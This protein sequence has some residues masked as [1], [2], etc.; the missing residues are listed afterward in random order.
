M[1]PRHVNGDSTET[2]GATLGCNRLTCR[3]RRLTAVVGA[4]RQQASEPRAR[5]RHIQ[6]AIAELEAEV[7]ATN[8]RLS[9]L[10]A[11]TAPARKPR[12]PPRDWRTP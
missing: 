7:A 4:L 9:H 5:N 6:R 3:A 1:K 2:R 10:A 8:A 12:D 11:G